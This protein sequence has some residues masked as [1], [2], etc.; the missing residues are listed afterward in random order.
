MIEQD[1]TSNP[2][3]VTKTVIVFIK[4]SSDFTID[5][6]KYQMVDGDWEELDNLIVGD[7]CSEHDAAK[8][9]KLMSL[10]HQSMTKKDGLQAVNNGAALIFCHIVAG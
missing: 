8:V 6:P 2:H 7:C 4:I 10:D 1:S 5:S 9:E 3:P